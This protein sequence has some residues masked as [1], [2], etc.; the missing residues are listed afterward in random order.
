MVSASPTHHSPPTTQLVSL[1]SHSLA[2]SVQTGLFFQK[3]WQRPLVIVL[4]V[5]CP[6]TTRR[7]NFASY[8][9]RKN[10]K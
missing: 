4:K 1:C 3:A 9:W 8:L 5:L 2:L 7:L 10:T 6:P